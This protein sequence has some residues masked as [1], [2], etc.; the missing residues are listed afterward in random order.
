MLTKRAHSGIMRR[1][2]FFTTENDLTQI[3]MTIRVLVISESPNI[4]DDILAG[5]GAPGFS[6]NAAS[7]QDAAETAAR[8]SPQIILA[9]TA[10]NGDL[11]KWQSVTE[12]KKKRNLPLIAIVPAD[13]LDGFSS[14]RDS[15]D[16]IIYPFKNAE[17]LLRLER[18]AEG[19]LKAEKEAAAAAGDTSTNTEVITSDGLIIDTATCEVTVDGVKVDLTFKEYELLK[20]MAASRGR[21]FTREVLLDKIWGYDYFGGD[22]TVDVHVRRLRSKIEDATHTYIETVRNIGYKFIKNG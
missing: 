1:I 18:M 5:T 15:D 2:R 8:V 19:A 7:F 6:V 10:G 22:R 20:L 21:V 16:F 4:T 12:L 17:L 3:A 9:E 11:T 14:Y 13:M